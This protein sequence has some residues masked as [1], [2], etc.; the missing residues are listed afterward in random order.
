MLLFFNWDLLGFSGI[1]RK[2]V[3]KW[4][5]KRPVRRFHLVLRSFF[6]ATFLSR[7]AY[8]EKLTVMF[9]EEVIVNQGD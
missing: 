3:G 6:I 2:R 1:C 4:I 5:S 7:M 9:S 8:A